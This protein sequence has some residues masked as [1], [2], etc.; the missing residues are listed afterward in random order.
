MK[1]TQVRGNHEFRMQNRDM[2]QQGALVWN[3]FEP[4]LL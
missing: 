3:S 1:L 4:K 2:S